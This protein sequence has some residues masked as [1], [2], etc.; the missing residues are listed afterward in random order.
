MPRTQSAS[1]RLRQNEKR[2]TR[3]RTNKSTLKKELK[4]FEKELRAKPDEAPKLLSK[5]SSALDQAARKNAIPKGRADR[6]KSRLALLAQ[7]VQKET[8]SAKS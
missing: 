4:S 6:K 2:R 8:A 1:K 7:R 5:V 3:N